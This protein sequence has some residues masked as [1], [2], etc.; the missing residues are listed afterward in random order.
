MIRFVDGRLIDLV[1]SFSAPQVPSR[2]TL[3]HSPRRDRRS[4]PHLGVR[5]LAQEV[6]LLASS[7]SRGEFPRFRFFIPLTSTL[8]SF[9]SSFADSL[10]RHPSLRSNPNPHHRLP[11][12][13]GQARTGA[14]LASTSRQQARS[15]TFPPLFAL[16][17]DLLLTRLADLPSSSSFLPSLRVTP[18]RPSPP[19]PPTTS[20]NSSNPT[21]P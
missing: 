3:P 2:S 13:Q 6:L 17:L 5:G 7:D 10:A 18:T 20:S 11:T 8:I 1:L 19:E 15:F 16:A 9:V 12:S 21:Q 14:E 4:P